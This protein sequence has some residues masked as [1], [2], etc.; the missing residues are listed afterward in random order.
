MVLGQ[1]FETES[2]HKLINVDKGEIDN[3]TTW[4]NLKIL[5]HRMIL[6]IMKST[7]PMKNT[8][9]INII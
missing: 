8:E 4:R 1:D 3:N 7:I 5:K 9:A 6:K 2:N